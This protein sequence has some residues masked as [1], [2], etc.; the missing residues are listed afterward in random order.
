MESMNKHYGG[1]LVG[2]RGI[3]EDANGNKD[4]TNY[5]P[6]NKEGNSIF[7]ERSGPCPLSSSLYYGGQEDMYVL[8]SNVKNMESHH[9]FKKEG[10]QG[11]KHRDESHIASRGNW[12][13][14]SL[15]Y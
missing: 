12:W 1:D 13:E 14:G 9:D 2:N 5:C 6:S 11:D 7:Q 3:T 4:G 15:Y 10:E 8:C